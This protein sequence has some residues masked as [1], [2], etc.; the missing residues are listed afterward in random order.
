M[1]NALEVWSRCGCTSAERAFPQRLELDVTLELPLG[2]AGRR[3]D[4]AKTVDY[5]AV[6]ANLKK[7]LEAGEFHLAEAVAERAAEVVLSDSAVAAV[8]VQVRKR[9]LPGIAWAGVEIRRERGAN[10]GR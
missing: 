2:E 4:L 3:D 7:A 9:A 1:I 5:A 6:V 8:T 10:V